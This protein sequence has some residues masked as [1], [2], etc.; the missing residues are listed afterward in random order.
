MI[1]SID[2]YNSGKLC[3]FLLRQLVR[4]HLIAIR[5]EQRK[6]RLRSIRSH[7]AVVDVRSDAGER[8]TERCIELYLHALRGIALVARPD[9]AGR[10]NVC[11]NG[12]RIKMKGAALP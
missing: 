7:A 12:R 3:N 4:V 9:L 8:I 5:P 2:L 1:L 11:E 10:V 6:R